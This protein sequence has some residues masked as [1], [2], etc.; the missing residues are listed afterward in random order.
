MARKK[1]K[2]SQSGIKLD[3]IKFILENNGPVEGVANSGTFK[4]NKYKTQI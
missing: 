1:G 3:I 4:E 2:I